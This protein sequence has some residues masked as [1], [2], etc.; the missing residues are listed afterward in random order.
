MG[1]SHI[2][3]RSCFFL[4]LLFFPYCVFCGGEGESSK[5]ARNAESRFGASG[6]LL[7]FSHLYSLG[8]VLVRV[9]VGCPLSVVAVVFPNSSTVT[10]RGSIM[11]CSF[12]QTQGY[13]QYV[14]MNVADAK[15]VNLKFPAF[16]CA[17]VWHKR[18]NGG[19][20]PLGGPPPVSFSSRGLNLRPLRLE[21]VQVLES[22]E[23]VPAVW[24][25][26]LHDV[27]L[28]G[29]NIFSSMT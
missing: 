15:K 29:C 7:G 6:G 28:S 21:K 24:R 17:W 23:D 13:S 20:Q 22:C 2:Q 19:S 11:A 18:S 8:L 27:K 25:S 14:V 1:A 4:F 12:Q 26:G 10:V 3:H 5:L 9:V 16:F